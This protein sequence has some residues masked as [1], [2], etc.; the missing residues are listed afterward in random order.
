MD[1]R[2]LM[3]M[4]TGAAALGAALPVPLAGASPLRPLHPGAT[5]GRRR[6]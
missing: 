3:M 4:M 1:R 6:R 2:S 5:R